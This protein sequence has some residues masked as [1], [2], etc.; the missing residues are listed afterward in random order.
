MEEKEVFSDTRLGAP[1]VRVGLEGEGKP[2]GVVWA[3]AK[4]VEVP[5]GL[6]MQDLR[7]DGDRMCWKG[8]RATAGVL[9]DVGCGQ[10]WEPGGTKLV[11]VLWCSPVLST[12]RDQQEERLRPGDCH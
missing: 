6:G 11:R 9:S 1:G 4:Q 3:E 7:E 5:G 10:P 8:G 2:G 12:T